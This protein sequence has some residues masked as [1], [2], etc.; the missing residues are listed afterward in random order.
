MGSAALRL[1]TGV[2]LAGTASGLSAAETA[3]RSA[4]SRPGANPPAAERPPAIATKKFGGSE[5]VS[6]AD[7]AS[8]LGLKAAWSERG[9]T[10]S[11]TGAAGRGE[12]EK[13]SRE[14]TLNGLRVFLGDPVLESGGQLYVSRV[15]FERCLTPHFRPGL[16][17]P[18]MPRPKTIV[19]D[20]GHGG[21]DKGTSANEKTYTLD[22]ARRAKKLLEAAGH[23]VVLTRDEDVFLELPQRSAIA[24]ASGANLFASI[25]FNAVPNDASTSGVEMAS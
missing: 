19:L 20:P 11:L 22:V 23:R 14:T 25:H 18:A 6:I 10:V 12:I 16:G 17:A 2:L 15:D 24:V 8:R 21:K 9:R 13:D 3:G 5:Y 1:I 7:V 4:P